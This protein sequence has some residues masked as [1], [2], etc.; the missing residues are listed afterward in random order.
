MSLLT[1]LVELKVPLDLDRERSN[2]LL[3][4]LF[5]ERSNLEGYTLLLNLLLLAERS[6]R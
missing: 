5:K 2:Q 3:P 6:N 4:V 1:G